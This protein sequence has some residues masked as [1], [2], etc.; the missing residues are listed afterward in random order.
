MRSLAD[1]SIQATSRIREVLVSTNDG[2]REAVDLS[3]RSEARIQASLKQFQSSG[4]QLLSLTNIVHESTG[5]VRQISAAVGQQSAGVSQIFAALNAL[6]R[7]MNETVERL[8][9]T[10]DAVSAVEQV[11][12]SISTALTESASH[13]PGAR[14]SGAEL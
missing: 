2:I 5:N 1:L 8:K 10:R 6:S 11:A 9:E 4:A 12:N 14:P 13:T 3:A 7:Q